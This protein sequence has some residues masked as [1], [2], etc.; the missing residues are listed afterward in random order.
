M[1]PQTIADTS[2]DMDQ[3]KV[4]LT[5]SRIRAFNPWN[6]LWS[7]LE[8]DGNLVRLPSFERSIVLR[9]DFK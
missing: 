2:I 8:P 5:G 1:A 4:A 6:G 9:I 7:E 3:Y